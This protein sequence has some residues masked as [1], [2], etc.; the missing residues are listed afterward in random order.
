MNALGRRKSSVKRRVENLKSVQSFRHPS[1]EMHKS[2]CALTSFECPGPQSWFRWWSCGWRATPGCNNCSSRNWGRQKDP[3][4]K[5]P[6]SSAGRAKMGTNESRAI[7]KVDCELRL[8]LKLIQV[9]TYS[10]W[11]QCI[12]AERFLNGSICKRVN[13]IPLIDDFAVERTACSSLRHAG[14]TFSIVY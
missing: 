10:R 12:D 5:L 13:E 2:P 3:L 7:C 6:Y 11:D 8:N 1:Q 9:T 4:A 14:D